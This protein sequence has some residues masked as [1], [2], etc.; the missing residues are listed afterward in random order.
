MSLDRSGFD[1]GDVARGTT[2]E[3]AFRLRNDGS[4]P[5]HIKQVAL[6]PPLR[7]TRMPAQVAPGGQAL[8][9]VSMET[10][11]MEGRFDGRIVLTLDDSSSLQTE[12]TWSG[13]IVDPIEVAPVPAF[14]LAGQRGART[15]AT[16]TITNHM[17]E[18]LRLG[19]PTHPTESF[20]SRLETLEEGRRY[21]LAITLVPD[22][23]RGRHATDILIATSSSE[24]PL[25]RIPAHTY[26][27]ERVYAFPDAVDLGV[28]RLADVRAR[29]GLLA[30]N[31]QTLMVYRKG[32]V[33]FRISATTDVPG[34]EIHADR[35]PSGDRYQLT[36]TLNPRSNLDARAIHGTIRIET[37]DADFPHLS[38]PVSGALIDG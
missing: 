26:L 8:I 12:L 2:V 15:E 19:E 36:L 37:N 18:A 4:R 1:F 33:D 24:V 28:F 13:R 7:V 10:R 21:R 23:P 16:L 34:L 30:Q 6:T 20:V 27:R 29:P 5:L 35:G 22:G 38:V 31:A 9:G 32:G 3:H 17:P 11:G 25:L 14:Y